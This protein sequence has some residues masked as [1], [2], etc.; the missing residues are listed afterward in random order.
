MKN[1]TKNNSYR[2]TC[3][4]Y[5]TKNILM[6]LALFVIYTSYVQDLPKF[7]V[8]LLGKSTHS[9]MNDYIIL[10]S[11]G[12][13]SIVFFE[14]LYK[15]KL[16]NKLKFIKK[17]GIDPIES[18]DLNDDIFNLNRE[19]I[20]LANSSKGDDELIDITLNRYN[21]I[22][23]EKFMDIFI[24]GDD[25]DIEN[26]RILNSICKNASNT[27]FKNAIKTNPFYK[28]IKDI[29]VGDSNDVIIA[30]LKENIAKIYKIDFQVYINHHGVL[31][32]KEQFANEASLFR[33]WYDFVFPVIVSLTAFSFMFMTYFDEYKIVLLSIVLPFVFA[34][35][36]KNFNCYKEGICNF[37]FNVKK[38]FNRMFK[39]NKKFY[40]K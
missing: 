2:F 12:L 9:F 34:N 3:S 30:V 35:I 7:I 10:I 29:H 13:F 27:T 37:Y 6:V 19:I 28:S 39:K 11:F 4:F 31:I 14:F 40:L 23:Y 26:I 33:F 38:M 21:D 1:C 15:H 36:V 17:S 5:N 22:N 20:N 18:K 24:N 32:S 25:K 8:D 16:E